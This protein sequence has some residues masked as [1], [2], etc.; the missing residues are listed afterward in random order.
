MCR[1]LPVYGYDQNIIL[2][3]IANPERKLLPNASAADR[4]CKA[5]TL[6]VPPMG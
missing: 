2:I 1:S 4:G 6:G 3:G 5:R